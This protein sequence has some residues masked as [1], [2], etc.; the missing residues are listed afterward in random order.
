MMRGLASVLMVS[1]AFGA[2]AEVADLREVTYRARS[3]DASGVVDEAEVLRPGDG[4]LVDDASIE[5]GS[6]GC[7]PSPSLRF[8]RSFDDDAP[9]ATGFS[10]TRAREVQ[11]TVTD[12]DAFSRPR[13][14][15][16]RA[17]GESGWGVVT[18]SSSG[19]LD[20]AK[21][22]FR[23]RVDPGSA[24]R[25][26]YIGFGGCFHDLWNDSVVTYQMTDGTATFVE[27]NDLKSA[28]PADRWLGVRF[29]LTRTGTS[30]R[31]RVEIDG[32]VV[33]DSPLREAQCA[34]TGLGAFAL[35][36]SGETIS[37]GRT[38]RFDDVRFEN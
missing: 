28:I 8:C 21:L 17:T 19:A 29:E 6:D 26:A 11:I 31:E 16:F 1:I 38:I 22:G 25:I 23:V 32:T 14:L 27:R 2:C 36:L 12:E 20:T 30:V 5:L 4:G 10:E 15:R 35:T 33:L 9:P 18:R 7:A 13:A 34:R 37:V 24:L 3:P